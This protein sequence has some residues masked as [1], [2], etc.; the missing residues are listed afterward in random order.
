MH[1]AVHSRFLKLIDIKNT[2]I[3]DDFENIGTL[4]GMI[5]MKFKEMLGV[6]VVRVNHQVRAHFIQREYDGTH[7]HFGHMIFT[8]RVS[9]KITYPLQV[10][11]AARYAILIIHWPIS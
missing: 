10:G 5:D 11:E 1:Q 4:A 9:D 7:L 8:Q 3:I 2:A 6:A